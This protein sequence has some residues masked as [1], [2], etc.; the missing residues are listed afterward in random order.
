LA[1]VRIDNFSGDKIVVFFDGRDYTVDDEE[2]VTVEAVEKGIHEV[3]IHRARV[4]METEDYHEVDRTDIKGNIEKSDKSFH[5]QLDAVFE[6]NI[7]SGKSVMTVRT[8]VKAKQK[9]GI[10]VL[11]SG[12]SVE[13]SGG[14]VENL[15]L[16]F[17]NKNVRK[18]FISHHIK[19]ALLP[20]GAGGTVLLIMGIIALIANIAGEAINIGGRDFT[21]PWSIGLTVVALGFIGYAIYQIFCALKIAKNFSQK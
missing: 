9:L 6:L 16:I 1:N 10:D 15:K 5:T 18:N 11:L 4:P 7:N 19:D 2:K 3:R 20:V 21:Y 8:K 14:K 13:E 17:S 12:Y